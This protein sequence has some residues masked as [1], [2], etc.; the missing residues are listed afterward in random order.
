MTLTAAISI[1]AEAF[2]GLL[3]EG[4]QCTGNHTRVASYEYVAL[5]RYQ[6]SAQNKAP[7][8]LPGEL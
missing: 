5:S 3:C 2:R 8:I 1:F 6:E 4:G 7:A